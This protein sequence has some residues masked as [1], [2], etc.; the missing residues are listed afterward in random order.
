MWGSNGRIIADRQECQIYLR[1]PH[2]ALAGRRQGWTIRYTTDLTDEV[3]FY[4][5]GE[6]YSAQIDYFAQSIKRPRS[7]ARTRFRSALEADRVV[8]MITGTAGNPQPRRRRRPRR[9][10]CSVAH[11]SDDAQRIAAQVEAHDM[12]RVLFGDNQF[13]GVNHMS[14]EKARAQA[15]RFQDTAGIIDVL[16]AA[17][18][19][20]HP[21]VH[22]HDARAHGEICDHFRA[23]RDRYPD[24]QFYPVHAVRAQV[25]ERRHRARHARR[26]A[27]V[28]ARDG[29]IGA[30]LKGG[31]AIAS[32]DIEAIMQLL[33][34]A[35]MKM[36]AGLRH[37]VI[38]LQ[39]VVTDLLLGL[40]MNDAFRMFAR[41]RAQRY[42]R[43]ARLHHD[44]PADAARC[45]RRRRA[46]RIR[47]CA[48]TS[49]R[50]AS[51]CAA[52]VELYEKTIAH[53][54]LPA[55]RDV[56]LGF[57]RDPAARGDRVCL[58]ATQ[59]ESIV[60]GASSAANIRQTKPLI[61]ELSRRPA[62]GAKDAPREKPRRPALA[63][64]SG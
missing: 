30:M 16:D 62:G 23:N 55:D 51:A 4:L 40:G 21:H 37:P 12:D 28:P 29:A 45:S 61:D 32:K 47:S 56:G 27:Q 36:F 2:A 26:A 60:F 22:V 19:G 6:E 58:R 64:A 46:S 11:R 52:G 41:P 25:C 9:Q 63:A 57:G 31:V 1:E 13:F 3:W 18:A 53:A 33:I 44:E 20:G 34:D 10:A 48:P 7:T 15:M 54:P 17:Y 5:R 35:E 49:T 59:I 39:N 42:R 8:A 43:R 50:S 38:F 24:Y 14:E